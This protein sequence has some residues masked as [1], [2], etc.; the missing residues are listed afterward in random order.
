[1][2]VGPCKNCEEREIGCHS[3]CIAYKKYRSE[4]EAVAK[5]QQEDRDMENL[6]RAHSSRMHTSK[7][8]NI[9]RSH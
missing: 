4:I 2:I 1:M 9:I 3:H 8:T 6:I 5:K 7:K